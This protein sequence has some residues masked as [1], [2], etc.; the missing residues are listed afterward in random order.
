MLPGEPGGRLAA[1]LVPRQRAEPDTEIR[2]FIAQ[3]LPTFYQPDRVFWLPELPRTAN[4][5]CDRAG[6]LSSFVGE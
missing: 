1:F 2:R 4:G 6:L 3:R 5:K